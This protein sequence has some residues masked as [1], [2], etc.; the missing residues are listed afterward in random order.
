VAQCLGDY[1]YKRHDLKLLASRDLHS[2]EAHG[3]VDTGFMSGS[4]PKIRYVFNSSRMLENG[5]EPV[6]EARDVPREDLQPKV[7]HPDKRVLQ[8]PTSRQ[9]VTPP[10]SR[11]YAQ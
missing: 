3:I 10:P 4:T 11:G 7:L 6:N 9:V 5:Y 8:R 2:L 1:L